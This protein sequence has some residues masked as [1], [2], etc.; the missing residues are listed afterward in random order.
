MPTLNF[1]IE[2]R[3]AGEMSEQDNVVCHKFIMADAR[4]FP[5]KTFITL[6]SYFIGLDLPQLS[7]E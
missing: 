1:K 5:V 4:D 6:K 7:R 2:A 3:C